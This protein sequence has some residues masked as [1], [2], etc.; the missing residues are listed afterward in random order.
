MAEENTK[1]I[2]SEGNTSQV[3]TTQ[4][5]ISMQQGEHTGQP[6]YSNLTTVHSGQGVVIVDFGFIDPHIINSLNHMAG[7]GEKTANTINAKMSCRMAISI[8]S[9]AQLTQQLNQLLNKRTAVQMPIDQQ[10][11]TDLANKTTSSTIPSD[12]KSSAPE[13]NQSGFRFPWSKKTH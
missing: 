4:V 9:A 3:R 6:I 10:K 7:S 13:G 8:D 5:K 12:E 1:P 11:M 2:E